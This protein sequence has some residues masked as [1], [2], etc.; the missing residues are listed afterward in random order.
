MAAVEPSAPSLD[1]RLQ[2]GIG[3]AA[4][5]DVV[6]RRVPRG[7]VRSGGQNH[8]RLAADRPVRLGIGFASPLRAAP[9]A[10][11]A[12]LAG[13]AGRSAGFVGRHGHTHVVLAAAGRTV[14][15]AAGRD[16]PPAPPRPPVGGPGGATQAPAE[17]VLPAFRC[18]R[19]CPPVPAL[20]V[21]PAVPVVPLPATAARTGSDRACGAG[22]SGGT[23]DPGG[24]G[25]VPAGRPARAGQPRVLGSRFR[26]PAVPAP[27]DTPAASPVP[28][29]PGVE[30]IAVPPAPVGLALPADPVV[31]TPLL[32]AS[33]P[34]VPPP[35]AE[36]SP[37]S[38]TLHPDPPKPAART[39]NSAVLLMIR[40]RAPME[41]KCRGQ[42][43]AINDPVR[44]AD[45]EPVPLAHCAVG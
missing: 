31:P 37:D 40:M 35:P 14:G 44:L 34:L 23:R 8:R 18:S 1:Q 24:A 11:A 27:P 36:A 5:S 3:F 16:R 43:L 39:R 2:Y 15:G 4:G 45:G 38:S 32:P 20:P 17:P 30:G 10:G 22:P 33:P 9:E 42:P 25:S 41:D 12:G 7:A 21:T 13:G 26:V 6:P 28:A 19:R 29:V